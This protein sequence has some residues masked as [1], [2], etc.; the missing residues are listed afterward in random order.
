MITVVPFRQVRI[1]LGPELEA[2]RRARSFCAMRWACKYSGYEQSGQA[3]G[4]RNC[5]MFPVLG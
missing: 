4:K 1:L 3:L 5:L 2:G